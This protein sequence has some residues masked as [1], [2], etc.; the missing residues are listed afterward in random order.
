MLNTH[1]WIDG[2]NYRVTTWSVVDKGQTI[3]ILLKLMEMKQ[4]YG[5][6]SLAYIVT[7]EKRH[8]AVLQGQK[9]RTWH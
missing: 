5:N 3:T 2:E 8:T 6:L 7:W 9:R 1:H 4:H